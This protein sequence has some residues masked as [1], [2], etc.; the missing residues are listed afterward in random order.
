MSVLF[1]APCIQKA[2]KFNF[3]YDLN[4]LKIRHHTP[5]GQHTRAYIHPAYLQPVLA[6]Q[7]NAHLFLTLHVQSGE[8]LTVNILT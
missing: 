8:T 3:K 1:M 6:A 5:S 4:I 7:N 2:D